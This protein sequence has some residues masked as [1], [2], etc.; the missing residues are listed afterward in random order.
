[1]QSEDTIKGDGLLPSGKAVLPLG[2]A[3]EGITMAP[4]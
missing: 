3:F 1:M 2:L 4:P